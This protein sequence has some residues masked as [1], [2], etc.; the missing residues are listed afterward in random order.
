MRDPA[1]GTGAIIT[2]IITAITARHDRGGGVV[3]ATRW[4]GVSQV[5]ML[6]AMNHLSP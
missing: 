3:V 1:V 4:E 2:A 5:W 6:C